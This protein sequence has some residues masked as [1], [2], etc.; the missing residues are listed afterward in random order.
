MVF[1]RL[2]SDTFKHD[3]SHNW[4]SWHVRN[5]ICY[6]ELMYTVSCT[7]LYSCR[8]V[9]TAGIIL[10]RPPCTP[11]AGLRAIMTS[12][13]YIIHVITQLLY[14]WVVMIWHNLFLLLFYI[15]HPTINVVVET[16]RI[17]QKVHSASLKSMDLSLISLLSTDLIISWCFLFFMHATL[18]FMLITAMLEAFWRTAALSLCQTWR[19]FQTARSTFSQ[20]IPESKSS[21]FTLLSTLS[22]RKVFSTLGS[23]W[24]Q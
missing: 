13:L 1:V 22:F 5:M 12:S 8:H 21:V 7:G 2:W 15:N 19:K 18:L 4:H 11:S 17:K 9:Y 23:V 14:Q 10:L 24:Y 20:V 16:L 3:G 6:Y